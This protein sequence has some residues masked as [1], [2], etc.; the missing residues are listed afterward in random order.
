M[1]AKN[2][3]G[4]FVCQELLKCPS[5]KIYQGIIFVNKKLWCIPLLFMLTLAVK[6]AEKLTKLNRNEGKTSIVY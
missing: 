5:A 1:S 4:I 6:D 2:Y 3:W